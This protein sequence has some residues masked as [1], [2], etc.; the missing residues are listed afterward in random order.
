MTP[1]PPKAVLPAIVAMMRTAARKLH[2]DS[3]AFSIISVMTMI[4]QFPADAIGIQI[5]DHRRR[6][7]RE[8]AAPHPI[9]WGEG[10]GHTSKRRR[11]LSAKNNARHVLEVL[12]RFERG[13]EMDDGLFTL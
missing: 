2:H 8:N 5:R 6:P 10:A 9:G 11:Y 13:D 7:S 3:A 4:D 1:L 12:S